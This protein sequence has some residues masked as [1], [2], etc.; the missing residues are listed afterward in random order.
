LLCLFHESGSGIDE[1]IKFDFSAFTFMVRSG[2]MA[3]KELDPVADR[4]S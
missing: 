3:R 4:S 2:P 1:S